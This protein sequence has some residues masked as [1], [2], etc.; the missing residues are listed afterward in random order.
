MTHTGAMF[1]LAQ[2]R[3]LVATL[4]PRIDE[5]IRVRADLT[6]L[7]TDLANHGLSALG[8]R[9]E[10]KGLEARLHAILDEIG[11]HGIQIKGVA[12]VL[13]DFPGERAGRQVLWCWLE[14]DTDVRWS[15][16]ADCG[17]AGRR[18]I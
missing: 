11:Q 14:G 10:V 9:P 6:E 5:L 16:R 3:H 17:F 7:Q 4:H 1:T 8:G 12:P 2:A 15:H 13:L 18:P